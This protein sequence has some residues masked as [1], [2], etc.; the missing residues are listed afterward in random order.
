MLNYKISV[1]YDG[2]DYFGWQSQPSGNTVQDILVKA[3]QQITQQKVNLI[4]SGR[5]DSGV[6]ALGQIANFQ[7][8]ENIDAHKF[9]HSLNSILPSTI[10]IN[11]LNLAHENFHA[12][13]DAVKRSYIYLINQNKSP[14][15]NKF[16]Y[17]CSY[18]DQI[19]IKKLKSLSKTIIGEHDFTSFC[20]TNT[21]TENKIC[22]IFEVGWKN[23]HNFLVFKIEA[24]RFLHGMVRTIVGTLLFAAVKNKDSKFILEVLKSKNRNSAGEAAPAKGL[25][26]Y[27]VKY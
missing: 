13:F 5:T 19:D 8:N 1:Q 3:I 2:T 16:S 7:L 26:L 24:N 12:R 22:T 9:Q 11:S 6:H 17:Q 23:T 27:K 14:F 18:L 25:F 21:D 20:K 10:S 4:G 15:Y